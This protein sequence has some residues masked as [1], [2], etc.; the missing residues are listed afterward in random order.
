[1]TFKNKHHSNETIEK[2]R[3]SAKSRPPI[4]EETRAKLA[5]AKRGKSNP[6]WNGGRFVDGKG[7]V[8]VLAPGNEMAD[9]NGYVTEHR[10]VMSA[11]LGR[12]LSSGE[13]VHHKNENRQDNSL[14]NLEL[15]DA[16]AH[17]A[18]HSTGRTYPDRKGRAWTDDQRAKVAAALRGKAKTD[19]ARAKQSASMRE[20]WDRKRG[21]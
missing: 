6:K 21:E 16:A 1:M 5:D 10:L 4:S 8:R 13:H 2:M 3:R 15:T 17:C 19:E 20:V 14:A 12:A 9:A 18:K 11:H 7:Y